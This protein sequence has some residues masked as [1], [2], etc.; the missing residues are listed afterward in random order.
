MRVVKTG[1][2][3]VMVALSVVKVTG[4]SIAVGGMVTGAGVTD[5][6]GCVRYWSARLSFGKVIVGLLSVAVESSDITEPE[7]ETL[8]CDRGL[9]W[10]VVDMADNKACDSGL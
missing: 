4:C 9:G 10:E 2:E 1:A 6:G 5:K 3:V 8:A 7:W